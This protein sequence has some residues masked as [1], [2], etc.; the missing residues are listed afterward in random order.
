MSRA[1]SRRLELSAA[2]NRSA[3]TVAKG[4]QPCQISV[5]GGML[6]DTARKINRDEVADRPPLLAPPTVTS[7]EPG[8]IPPVLIVVEDDED[9]FALLERA[10]LKAGGTARVW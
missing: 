1:D 5:E 2:E 10:L 9:D 4:D 3:A 8:K 7:Y 6:K